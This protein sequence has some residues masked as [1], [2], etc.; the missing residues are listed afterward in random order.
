MESYISD[1]SIKLSKFFNGLAKQ[2]LEKE[3]RQIEQQEKCDLMNEI[4]LKI[5][6]AKYFKFHTSQ[7]VEN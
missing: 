5:E 3:L 6:S 4:L 2:I 7:I 1:L